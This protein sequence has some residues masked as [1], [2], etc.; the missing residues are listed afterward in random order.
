MDC[1]ELSSAQRFAPMFKIELRKGL[2]SEN[3]TLIAKAK[4]LEDALAF[5]ARFAIGGSIHIGRWEEQSGGWVLT[6][7][8][9]CESWFPD[10]APLG[11]IVTPPSFD[12]TLGGWMRPLMTND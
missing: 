3:G 10:A 12:P 7:Y 8:D 6:V 9:W 4:T 5:T 1:A 11:Y 2:Y